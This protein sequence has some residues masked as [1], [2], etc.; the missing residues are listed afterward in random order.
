MIKKINDD[1]DK[2]IEEELKLSS[3]FDGTICSKCKTMQGGE[4]KGVK[5]YYC[6]HITAL[7][8]KAIKKDK[9]EIIRR[10]LKKC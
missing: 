7:I 5:K 9:Q 4:Y 1:L 2:L 10:I 3:I 8:D 6:E